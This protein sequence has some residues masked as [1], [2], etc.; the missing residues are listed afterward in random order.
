M[1]LTDSSLERREVSNWDFFWLSSPS[2]KLN[3][4]CWAHF[5]GVGVRKRAL[6][7]RF[8]GSMADTQFDKK[9]NDRFSIFIIWLSNS[10][11]GRLVK[12]RTD[13]MTI[14]IFGVSSLQSITNTN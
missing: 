10:F 5:G 8:N 9:T 12:R 1:R 7:F 4:Q 6:L 13:V 11:F 2:I 14:K 3:C